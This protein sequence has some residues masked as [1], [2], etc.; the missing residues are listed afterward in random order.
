MV[1]SG[2]NV[3]VVPDAAP[4]SGSRPDDLD[5]ALRLA[6]LGVL[7]AVALA[8]AIDLEQQALGQRVDDADAD[9]VQ[10]TGHL[11]ALAA[12]L[13]PGVEHG[14]HHLGRALALVR[15]ARVGV[16]RDATAVVVDAAAAVVLQGDDDAGGEARHRLVDG[17]VDDLR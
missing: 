1:G 3:T 2:Q 7:L 9:A 6:A 8:A 13:A 17:V 10:A 14:E 4:A 15:S 16:D 11:V 5:L 12:E